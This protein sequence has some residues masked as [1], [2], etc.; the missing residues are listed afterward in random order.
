MV[1]SRVPFSFGAMEKGFEYF[2][3]VLHGVSRD[4][5]DNP[6]H[7]NVF[8]QNPITPS[9]QEHDCVEGG[10]WA[11]FPTSNILDNKKFTQTIYQTWIKIEQKL[12]FYF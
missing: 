7:G 4:V 12:G 6:E 5:G 10:H 2:V 8:G 11:L 9:V 1:F 3:P